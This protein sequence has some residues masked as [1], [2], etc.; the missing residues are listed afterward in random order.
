MSKKYLILKSAI[1][2]C[3]PTFVAIIFSLIVNSAKKEDVDLLN[4]S[5]IALFYLILF[6]EWIR[7]TQENV[8]FLKYERY[9][10]LLLI[11][12]TFLLGIFCLNLLPDYK[13]T[14]FIKY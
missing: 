5:F 3:Y 11:L 12:V 1:E 14:Q 10:W 6:S 8:K 9:I 2:L 7:R 13:E 4:V